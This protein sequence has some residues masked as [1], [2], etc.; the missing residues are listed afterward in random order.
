M[1]HTQRF[2]INF[3]VPSCAVVYFILKIIFS[4]TNMALDTKACSAYNTFSNVN[5]GSSITGADQAG[6]LG[7]RKTSQGA[8]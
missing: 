2:I 6:F 1:N 7:C 8:A 4:S 3:G 5:K